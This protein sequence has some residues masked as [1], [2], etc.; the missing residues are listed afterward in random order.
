LNLNLSTWVQPTITRKLVLTLMIAILPILLFGYF[1]NVAGMRILSNNLA[2]TMNSNVENYLQTYENE[3]TRITKM[4]NQLVQL[5][6]DMQLLS[7]KGPTM[8]YYELDQTILRAIEKLVILRNS[9]E[10]I[11]N[12]SLSIYSLGRK[13]EA[14]S[15]GFDAIESTTD[16]S[17]NKIDGKEILRYEQGT[18][19][20]LDYYPRYLKAG[21][22]KEILL[23]VELSRKYI[24]QFLSKIGADSPSA[25]AFLIGGNNDWII[26]DESGADV[27]SKIV[28]L[29]P[30]SSDR[31][32]GD[33]KVKINGK[34][35]MVFH[36]ESA[37]LNTVIYVYISENDILGPLNEYRTWFWILSALSLFLIVIVP[38]SIYK[39]IHNPLQVLVRAF[40]KMEDGDF[41]YQVHQPRRDEFN[42]LFTQ[43]NKMA[44]RLEELIAKVIQQQ[45]TTK[46]AELKQL[47]SQVNPHFLYNSFF[48]IKAMAQVSDV[49]GIVALSDKLGYYFQFITRNG[50]DEIPLETEFK[51]ALAYIEIQTVRFRSRITV[52]VEDNITEGRYRARPV[53]RLILQPLLENA[54]AHGLKNKIS[55]G[56]I[57]FRMELAEDE[58]IRICIK[59][60][61]DELT[62]ELL[63]RLRN[64]LQLSSRSME[65]TGLINVHKRLKLMY[66]N[67]AGLHLH[68]SELGG[69]EVLLL[70]PTKGE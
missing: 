12:I 14:N 3:I 48:M 61:G 67:S 6:H 49:D 59:D 2:K 53:P 63:F 45:V 1:I 10:F 22:D 11:E 24:E 8:D 18:I 21:H 27:V 57:V 68:R 40:R 29:T 43:F 66:G 62:D 30:S 9:S 15:I 26:S 51:H 28:S 60:N 32:S 64:Q 7:V 70:L 19:H 13:F 65:T 36:K 39:V 35:Y 44:N 47:Q 52:V 54:Y 34:K 56:K 42:Y 31:T 38:I 41:K 46:Q 58:R 69:L 37:L 50:S 16:E 20:L 33:L 23:D 5:D 55:E 17:D 25:K 4:Q